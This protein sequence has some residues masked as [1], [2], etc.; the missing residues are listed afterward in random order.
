MT[1]GG[2]EECFYCGG[3]CIWNSDAD[4]DEVARSI[5]NSPLVKTAIFG[6]D[7]NWGSGIRGLSKIQGGR[8]C[9]RG[10][11]GTD[12]PG[13]MLTGLGRDVR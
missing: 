11:R 2:F 9:Q 5:A 4:A 6:H 8:R 10:D 1:V 13:L 7:A 12:G 3:R